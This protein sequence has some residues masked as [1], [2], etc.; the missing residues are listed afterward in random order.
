MPSKKRLHALVDALPEE[1][2]D[3]AE[4]VLEGLRLRGS[5]PRELRDAPIDDEPYTEEDRAAVEEAESELD[6]GDGR[7]LE[8][9][10]RELGL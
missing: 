3:A 10:K 4:R 7:S 2:Y 8:E 5:L 9:A 1:E 6:R